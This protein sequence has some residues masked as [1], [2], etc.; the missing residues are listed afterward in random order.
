MPGKKCPNC[1]ELTL[2]ETNTGRQ[3]S[4][5]GFEVNLPPNGGKGGKGKRCVLCGSFTVFNGKC[6]NCGAKEK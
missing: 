1:G 2:F 5:C 3:C 6:T 4:N